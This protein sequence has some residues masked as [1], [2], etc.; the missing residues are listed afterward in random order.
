MKI[1]SHTSHGLKNEIKHRRRQI[2]RLQFNY[3]KEKFIQTAL[4]LKGKSAEEQKQKYFNA[5]LKISAAEKKLKQAESI[6]HARNS[7]RLNYQGYKQG[8]LS[9]AQVVS[10]YRHYKGLLLLKAHLLTNGRD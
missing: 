9:R 3:L 7:F 5:M 8:A 4:R 10:T 2:W 1:N 6:L